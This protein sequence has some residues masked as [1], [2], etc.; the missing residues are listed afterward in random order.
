MPAFFMLKYSK[1]QCISILLL[2]FYNIEQQ[3]FKR[4]VNKSNLCVICF[5]FQK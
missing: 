2:I 3:F 4:N 1:T 5:L